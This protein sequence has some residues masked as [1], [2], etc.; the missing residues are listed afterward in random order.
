MKSTIR[1]KLFLLTYGIILGFIVGLIILNNTFL[2]NYYIH[3]R[4]VALVQAFDELKAIDLDSNNFDDEIIEI[5]SKYSLSVR[6]IVQDQPVPRNIN[7]DGFISIPNL[8]HHLYGAQYAIPSQILTKIIVN[9]NLSVMKNEELDFGDKVSIADSYDAYLLDVNSD[10][11]NYQENYQMLGLFVATDIDGAENLFYI[12]T[13]TFSSIEDSI[14]IF[15]SFTFL[16]GFIFMILAGLIMYF[17]SYRFTNPIL[18]INRVADEISKLNFSQKVDIS[19]DDE[20]GDLG[21]SINKMS[22]Q[23]EKAII[24][25]QLSNDKLAK[26]ILYK[27]KIDT[28]RKEFIANASHELKTP[29][30]LIMG[31]GEALKLSDLDDNTKAEYLEIILDE[32]E[33]MNSLVKELLNLSQIESGK[34]E[35]KFSDFSIKNLIEDTVKLFSLI[36]KDKSIKLELNIEDS[37]VKSDY[38]QLQSVISNMIS[39]AIN[40]IDGEKVISITSKIIENGTSRVF[41][42]NTGKNIPETEIANIW[43][44]FYKVDKARTRDYGGQGLGLSIVKSILDTLGYDYGVKNVNDGVV[45]YFDI[46]TPEF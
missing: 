5:E 34:K 4:Q 13:I 38:D 2:H 45:F 24:E 19:N 6:I 3:N 31:Y 10:L 35:F 25:L 36:F 43:D 41:I 40:H 15:N 39:N 22:S 14:R 12:S 29:L 16:I 18:E 33:K 28:M 44:S 21:Y 46:D 23:L 32:A 7:V 20:I 9:Y 30:S 37:L 42:K 27:N 17:F 1:S 8:Y 26:E 11:Y